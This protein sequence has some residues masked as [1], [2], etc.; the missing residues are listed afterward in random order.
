[1][2]NRAA[3]PHLGIQVVAVK[4]LHVQELRAGLL[5][6]GTRT[7]RAD[8]IE[9]LLGSASRQAGWQRNKVGGRGREVVHCS[10]KQHRSSPLN[11]PPAQ[12]TCT[13]SQSR[14]FHTGLSVFLHTWVRSICSADEQGECKMQ[15]ACHELR[16]VSLCS[17]G[18]TT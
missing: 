1:M 15:I 17:C 12:R 4:A 16:G 7:S 10:I 11:A 14:S 6:Q 9:V 5:R 8:S 3:R 2:K 13:S 18:P